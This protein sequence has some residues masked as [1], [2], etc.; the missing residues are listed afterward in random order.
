MS[1]VKKYVTF[2]D[3]KDLPPA[4][5]KN[6]LP[7]SPSPSTSSIPSISS[8]T[9]LSSTPRISSTTRSSSIATGK[10]KMKPL[11]EP[12]PKTQPVSR[13]EERNPTAPERDFQR[14]PNSVT[15]QALAGGIFRGKSKQVWDYLW[16]VSR[17]AIT[18]NRTIRKSRKEIKI[19]SG[20]GSMVTVDA[21]IDHLQRLNLLKVSP[22]IGSLIGNLYE[23]FTPEEA[24]IHSVNYPSI[25]STSSISSPTQNLVD[26]GIPESSISRIT[27]PID[28]KTTYEDP[29]TFFKTWRDDDE[30]HTVLRGF[31]RVMVEITTEILGRPMPQTP[32]EAIL[33]EEFGRVLVGELKRAAANTATISSVPAFFSEHLRRRFS[34]AP[35]PLSL[36]PEDKEAKETAMPPIMKEQEVGSDKK[37]RFTLGQCREYAEHLQKSRQ[38]IVNPGGY[39]TTIYRTGEADELLEAFFNPQDQLDMN[40]CPDCWGQGF[41]DPENGEGKLT[42][43]QHIG[44]E[45]AKHLWPVV[46]E[47]LRLHAG[48]LSYQPT[49]LY[50]DVR[51]R[52]QQKSVLFD[53]EMVNKLIEKLLPKPPTIDSICP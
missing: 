26:L 10:A 49:D 6:P 34:R 47:L 7:D 29:N 32:Q 40:F 3:L 13:G 37:S 52:C 30:T 1:D 23:I 4:T 41:L 19:G 27:L 14:V 46:E 50:D 16:S 44:L 25:P 35:S 8:D 42:E 38:G 20:L 11:A 21:A 9:G 31:C 33:W 51:Y 48:D 15:R 5:P 45:T 2:R 28:S 17:G 53:A 43:C 24:G 12:L 36:P 39:A 22:A 18:P